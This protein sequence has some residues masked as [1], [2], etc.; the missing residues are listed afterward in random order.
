M[1]KD[2]H[3]QET[4]MSKARTKSKGK[5]AGKKGGLRMVKGRT[6]VSQRDKMARLPSM[7]GV[8]STARTSPKPTQK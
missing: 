2:N 8:K 5:Q 6:T 3:N 7:P 4:T 1:D